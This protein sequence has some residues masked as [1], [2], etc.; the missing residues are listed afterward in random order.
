MPGYKDVIKGKKR[1]TTYS[2]YTSDANGRV[3]TSNVVT[4]QDFATCLEDLAEQ[5]VDILE[6]IERKGGPIAEFTIGKTY[7]K[8]RID[9]TE[10]RLDRPHEWVMTGVSSRWSK[11][12][13]K[14][15][16]DGLIVFHCFTAADVPKALKDHGFDHNDLALKYEQKIEK[17][18]RE[19]GTHIPANADVAGGGRQSSKVYAG[20]VL[21]IA[22]KLARRQ[23]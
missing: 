23:N 14:K 8:K 22:F 7:V 5:V 3:V 13:D 20:Y 4:T 6:Q 10:F 18:L 12:Y 9:R 11:T 21:Y 19:E 15:R 17:H 1:G 2:V 16:Y